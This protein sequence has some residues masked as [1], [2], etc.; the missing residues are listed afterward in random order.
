MRE[1]VSQLGKPGMGVTPAKVAELIS[2]V[3]APEDYSG[4]RVLLIVPDGTRTAPIG[5]VFRA[6]HSQIA[7]GT[8]AFDV[9]VAL[10]THQPM[11]EAAICQRLEISEPE[12]SSTYAKV[13]FY[14]HAWNDPA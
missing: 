10:G 11:S 2:R 14:N 12:R 7:R 9:L 3:C 8:R 1:T 6:L 4:K 13:R 5:M